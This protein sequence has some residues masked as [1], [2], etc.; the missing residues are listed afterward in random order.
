MQTLV[1]GYG[2]T[3][4]DLRVLLTSSNANVAA[5]HSHL[6]FTVDFFSDLLKNGSTIVSLQSL[7][8]NKS[9]KN[10]A[11]LLCRRLVISLSLAVGKLGYM[12]DK[13]KR[14]R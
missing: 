3:P 7:V 8:I 2:K 6:V 12:F 9:Q 11:Q 10:K 1:E 14:A 5:S 13:G 4:I